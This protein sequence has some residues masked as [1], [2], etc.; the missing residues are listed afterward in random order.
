M[1]IESEQRAKGTSNIAAGCEVV[2]MVDPHPTFLR[3]PGPG[4]PALQRANGRD[5]VPDHDGLERLDESDNVLNVPSPQR[6]PRRRTAQIG[7]L[8][9]DPAREGDDARRETGRDVAEP[10]HYT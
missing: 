10:S 6:S 7:V 1:V 9:F 8:T 2:A 3:V 4:I 5:E